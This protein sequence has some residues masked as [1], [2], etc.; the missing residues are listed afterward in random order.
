MEAGQL[1]EAADNQSSILQ[2]QL[3]ELRDKECRLAQV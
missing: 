1:K 2:A 3:A